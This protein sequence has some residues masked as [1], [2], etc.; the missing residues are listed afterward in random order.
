MASRTKKKK[1]VK[2]FWLI[3]GRMGCD[4]HKQDYKRNTNKN[5]KGWERIDKDFLSPSMGRISV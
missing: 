4:K 5:I 1:N 2:I 3:G